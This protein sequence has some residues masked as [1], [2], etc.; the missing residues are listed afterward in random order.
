METAAEVSRLCR[1]VLGKSVGNLARATGFVQRRSK[2]TDSAFVQ[3]LE[4][5][6][7]STPQASAEEL[8]QTTAAVE[9]GV[10][11]QGLYARFNERAAWFL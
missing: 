11:P 4:F 8:A 1:L 10:S 2:I 5:G 3:T 9:V 7:L 6:W